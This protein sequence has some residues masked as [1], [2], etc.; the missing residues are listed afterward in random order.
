SGFWPIVPI[1]FVQYSKYSPHLIET[2]D[3]KPLSLATVSILGQPRGFSCAESIVHYQFQIF[4]N[5]A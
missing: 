3:A 4:K 5:M 2:M 1:K